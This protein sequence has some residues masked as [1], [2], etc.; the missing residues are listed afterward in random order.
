MKKILLLS[1]A[2]FVVTA[3]SSVGASH[4]PSF[5]R[6]AERMHQAQS[7]QSE[8]SSEAPEGGGASGALA[9]TR[10]KTGQTTPLMPSST[11][12]ANPTSSSPQR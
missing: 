3:C 10:Y 9:Q 11:S 12:S 4:A 7:E 8:V 1:A 2:A 5:G 6:S